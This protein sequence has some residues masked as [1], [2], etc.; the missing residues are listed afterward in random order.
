MKKTPTPLSKAR[1]GFGSSLK[2]SSTKK[3]PSQTP[4]PQN[5]NNINPPPPLPK[6]GSKRNLTD[7]PRQLN[8][9]PI[10]I[11]SKPQN[12]KTPKHVYIILC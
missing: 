8:L 7:K 10:A 12:P 2:S 3:L 9:N 5:P 6:G 1:V 4:K 11:K